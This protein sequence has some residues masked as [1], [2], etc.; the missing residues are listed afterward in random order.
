[1]KKQTIK[2]LAFIAIASSLLSSCDLLK[3]IEYKVTPSPLEMHGDSVKID[4]SGSLPVKG[5]KKKVKVEIQPMLGSTALEPFTIQGEKVSGNGQ[6]IK[7]KSNGSFKYSTFVAYKPE[8]ETAD[9]MVTGKVYKGKKN[10]EKK[11]Q[12]PDTKL[13]DATIITPYLVNKT[14]RVL[15]AKDNFVRTTEQSYSAKLNFDKAKAVVKPTELKDKD[16][17]DYQKWLT[18]AQTNPKIAIKSVNINGFASPEG[19]ETVNNPLSDE[20]AKAAQATVIELAKKANNTVVQSTTFNLSGRGE[21]M[22]GFETEVGK[23][24]FPQDKKDQV[25]RVVKSFSPEER[26]QGM[27]DMAKI[28]TELEKA[29]FPVLR[30]AEIITNYDLTGYSDDELKALAMSTPDSLDLEELLFTATLVKDLGEKLKIYQVAQK[31]YPTDYRTHN[32]VGAVLFM[33][34]KFN[35]A[36]THFEKANSLNSADKLSQNNLGAVAGVNGDRKK[37]RELLKK[38]SGAGDEVKY[39]NGILDIQ[40]GKYDDA[41]KNFG[42]KENHFNRALNQILTGDAAGAVKTIDGSDDKESAQ[43]YYLKAIAGARQ[44]NVDA[45]ANNLKSAIAKD[46]SYKAKAAKDREFLKYFDNP[47]FTNVVK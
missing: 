38:A 23:A 12:F 40:D 41:A 2:G 42:T 31:N 22:N 28:F 14:F 17:V 44:S 45:V 43:G 4:V 5:I 36:K 33:Q 29:V 27:A 1:M 15:L 13:A 20:R 16:I 34:G 8:F 18:A 24:N 32:N 11:D 46:A 7:Y 19:E 10:K 6:V 26:A 30:R 39:N 37:A 9:L 3:D 21:D 25:I 35:E 47:T